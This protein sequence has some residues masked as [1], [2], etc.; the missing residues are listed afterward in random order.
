MCA[1]CPFNHIQ[2]QSGSD[3]CIE[4]PKGEKAGIFCGEGNQSAIHVKPNYWLPTQEVAMRYGYTVNGSDATWLQATRRCAFE[5]CA[6]GIFNASL[7]TLGVRN[8]DD[9]MGQPTQCLHASG[10][11]CSTC[12]SFYHGANCSHCQR[13]LDI[14]FSALWSIIFALIMFGMRFYLRRGVQLLL[15]VREETES[16]L[17]EK[18]GGVGGKAAPGSAYSPFKH[19]KQ[20]EQ[21]E[22]L[23]HKTPLLPGQQ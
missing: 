15:E 7:D 5:T 2:W 21:L 9:I 19:G 14:A 6:G 4:C 13:A 8:G 23:F 17:R 3:Q 20:M 10:L 18:A 11:W 16:K 12:D 1:P 22:A